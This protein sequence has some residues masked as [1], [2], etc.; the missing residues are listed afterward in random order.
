MPTMSQKTTQD[1]TVKSP[2][3]FICSSVAGLM[4][5]AALEGLEFFHAR[6][7]VNTHH[8]IWQG[9]LGVAGMLLLAAWM[10]REYARQ[11]WSV[12]VIWL[13]LVGVSILG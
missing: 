9:T 10:R 11:L 4:I 1:V 5:F 7:D 3:K 8:D 12:T 13:V 6:L 2:P